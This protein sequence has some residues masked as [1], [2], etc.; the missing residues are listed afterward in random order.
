MSAFGQ[1]LK[2]GFRQ[3]LTG[4]AKRPETPQPDSL[5]P[6]WR[7]L[8]GQMLLYLSGEPTVW[9]EDRVFAPEAKALLD[10]WRGQKVVA[11]DEPWRV[12]DY[13]HVPGGTRFIVSEGPSALARA[14][15]FSGEASFELES[16][17]EHPVRLLAVSGDSLLVAAPLGKRSRP[18]ALAE[19]SRLVL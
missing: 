7:H 12:E 16:S 2:D 17:A 3:L 19:R 5:V 4:L 11:A 8:R 6:L 13:R 15:G 9:V 1:G 10:Q 18:S 14:L